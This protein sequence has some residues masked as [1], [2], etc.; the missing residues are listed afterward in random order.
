MRRWHT[1]V[2]G[3]AVSGAALYLAFRRADG[4]AIL[5]A[6][7]TARYVYVALGMGLVLITVMMRGL[8]WSA[9]TQGRLSP[10]DGFWLFNIGFLF[11]NILPA[12]IGEIARAVLAGRRPGM[13]FTSALSSIV[14][15]RLFDMVSVVVLFGIV[16]IG[17]DLPGWATSAG[18]LMGA[19]AVAGMIVLALAA[20]WPGRALSVGAHA[21]ALLPRLDRTRARQFLEPFVQ[22][23]GAV[24]DLRTFIV[25]LFL[26]I[27]AWIA[28]GIAAWA[29]MHAFWPSVPLIHGLLSV[30][31]A[32][33]GIA[34]PAAPSGV[35]PY[36]A[37]VI[38][39][40][41]A[42]GYQPDASRSFAIAMHGL[43]F[44]LTSV[45]GILGLLR[46]GISFSEVAR[47][48]EAAAH[49]NPIESGSPAGMPPL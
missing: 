21:L 31:A 7:R 43:N 46:D 23:L 30:A 19:G 18:A 11:N 5:L 28:S 6:F 9:L 33:L 40:L 20:R 34:V 48:A 49:P 8:R 36:E 35:G 45:C 38:G 3:L 17:L 2:I 12:R 37:A 24:S 27:A 16:L 22:G 4:S 44:I 47:Q 14:V 29:L 42:S 10:I 15:E 13:H 25:G 41:T 26:S 1:L 39:V 32:G